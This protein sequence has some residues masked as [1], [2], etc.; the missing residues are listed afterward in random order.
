M[1]QKSIYVAST[2]TAKFQLK[3]NKKCQPEQ[4]QNFKNFNPDVW[5]LKKPNQHYK[6]KKAKNPSKS[7]PNQKK[8]NQS[9]TKEP[10]QQK[11]QQQNPKPHHHHNSKTS[12][13]YQII[14]VPKWHSNIAANTLVTILLVL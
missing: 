5:L 4:K 7:K 12:K 10:E 9:N 8:S 2:Q 14:T 11:W 3:Q 6:K 1:G 13:K